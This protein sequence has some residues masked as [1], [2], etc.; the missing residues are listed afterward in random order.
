MIRMIQRRLIIP[1]GDTG[2]FSIPYLK[3][4]NPGDVA[5]FTIF[6]IRTKTK[7][8][9]KL[10]AAEGD[11][12]NIAFTHGDTVNLKP[13]KY[14]WDIKF[15]T[16]PQI[17]DDELVNGDE[18]D[19]YYAGF[20]LPEC[21]IRET[22]DT[23]LTSDDAPTSTISPESLNIIN[24]AINEILI[25]KRA[26]VEAAETAGL[27]ADAAAESAEDASN[28]ASAAN[29]SAALAEARVN[30]IESLSVEVDTGLEGTD[31]SVTY[32]PSTGVLSFIIPRGN[33]GNGI[34]SCVL[35]D[36]F[37]LTINYTNGDSTTTIPIRGDTPHLTIGE[38]TEGPHAI[39]TITGTDANPI[40][41]LTLPNAN[42]PTKVSELQNDA[43]Y[44]TE[45]QDL[46]NYV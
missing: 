26:A 31:A 5:V 46:S 37:T 2:S 20:S 18:V 12:L 25:T 13:G 1:R 39:A 27:K 41:N 19:S 23:L 22:G 9:Q 38:V 24:A 3:A 11:I 30:E 33:T 36:D 40:L 8:Y 32:T 17:I 10:I 34:A 14:L 44:L 45:H 28:S 7:M 42:V 29:Q 16:N 15:Y 43:G 6:D 21:E 4:I 35:N